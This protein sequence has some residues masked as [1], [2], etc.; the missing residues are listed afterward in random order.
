[1][2][3]G[4]GGRSLPP[5]SPAPRLKNP[6]DVIRLHDWLIGACHQVLA[7]GDIDAVLRN[8]L[9]QAHQTHS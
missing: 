4:S 2:W 1:V 6:A 5:A 9:P 3:D 8:F 7:S